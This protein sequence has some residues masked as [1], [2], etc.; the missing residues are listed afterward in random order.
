MVGI[1]FGKGVVLCEQYFGPITGPKSANIVDSKFDSAFE[2]SI[3]PV[4]K[5]F[6]MD[7]C[8]RQKSRTALHAVA[9]IGG[10][11]F[12]I[13]PRSPDLNPIENVFNLVVQKLNNEAI[14]KDITDETFQSFSERVKRCMLSFPVKVIDKI[15]STVEKR[16]NMVLKAKGQRIKY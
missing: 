2:N 6:L 14:E 4:L 1:L 11:V 12:K 13:S 7:G 10:L 16:I 15:I 8:P 5:R 3:S 9:Q